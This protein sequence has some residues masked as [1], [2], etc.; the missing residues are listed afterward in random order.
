MIQKEVNEIRRRLSPDKGAF[1]KIY[2]CFVNKQKEIISYIDTSIGL[3]QR[4]DSE[5]YLAL[6]KKVLSGGIGRSM[7]DIS[8]SNAQV[9]GSDEHALLMELRNSSLKNEQAREALFQKIISCVTVEEGNYVIL[10]IC[11]DYD[12]PTRSSDGVTK[13]ESDSV[14][15]YFICCVCPV[16]DGKQELAYIPSEQEFKSHISPMIVASPQ[17]GFMFPVFEDRG[18]NIYN[19]LFY[20]K[21]PAL[22]HDDFIATLFC[23]ETPMSAPEQKDT[24]AG[25]LA[26]TLEAECSFDVVQT[27]H[28]KIRERLTVHK[29]SKIPENP[30]LD[31]H[32]VSAILRSEGVS[33]EATEIFEEKCIERFGDD[34][35]LNPENI[36]NTKKFEIETPQIKITVDPDYSCTV[37]TRVIN[38]R[39]Y[40]LIPADEGVSVNGINV[41]IPSEQED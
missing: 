16:K 5:K 29:E 20:T 31:V 7:V 37:E 22:M 2:G 30:E 24:F 28:D 32:E 27:V 33:A 21:N 9:A 39:K 35:T 11:D 34:S 10:L 8:F 12:V 19:A 13:F 23:T 25:T 4:E 18:A 36:V 40:I 38:G 3:M 41:T 26:D 15:S 6:F 1:G 17:L 14:F